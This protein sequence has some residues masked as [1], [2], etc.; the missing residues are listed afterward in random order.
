MHPSRKVYEMRK[1][2]VYKHSSTA[3]PQLPPV[4][5]ELLLQQQLL[6]KKITNIENRLRFG[7][8][9]PLHDYNVELIRADLYLSAKIMDELL[10]LHAAKG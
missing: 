6:Q 8:S 7:Y 5:K 3:S 9:D 4:L 2:S 1:S 10:R